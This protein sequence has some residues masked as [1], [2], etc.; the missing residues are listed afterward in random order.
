MLPISI[1]NH[2]VL[3]KNTLEKVW[4]N[5][6][7]IPSPHFTDELCPSHHYSAFSSKR[8]L[9]FTVNK[10]LVLAIKEISCKFVSVSKTLDAGVEV[11]SISEI[12]K[13]NQTSF[14]ICVHFITF[15]LLKLA[16]RLCTALSQVKSFVFLL[17]FFVAV[18]N[19]FTFTLNS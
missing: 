17:T 14:R 2:V 4:S 8:I 19:I 9:P 12:A 13:T 18:T 1:K 10:W 3:S 16:V 15:I 11:A 7:V 5:Y 6:W